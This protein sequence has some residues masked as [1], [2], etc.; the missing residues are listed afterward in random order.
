MNEAQRRGVVV[1]GRNVAVGCD[2][3]NDDVK[4]GE[5]VGRVATRWLMATLTV[6]YIY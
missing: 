6:S 4:K 1:C 3:Y 5:S 2:K